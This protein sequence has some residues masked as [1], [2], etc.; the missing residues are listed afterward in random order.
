MELVIRR[1]EERDL[2]RDK[3][4]Q[5]E[6]LITL[7]QVY[8]PTPEALRSRRRLLEKVET[9]VAEFK[10]EIVGTAEY[11]PEEGEGVC[12]CMNLSV[13]LGSRGVG[14]GR[15]I[16]SWLGERAV[17][18]GFHTLRLRCVKET[19]NVVIFRRCGFHVVAEESSTLFQTPDGA[20]VTE[21]TLDLALL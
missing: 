7:R 8:S 19:G 9:V 11:Y 4:L 13:T 14:V 20:C 2:L 18:E 10:G 12:S 6:A 15:R 17:S 21:V 1:A 3:E 16:L 5:Q